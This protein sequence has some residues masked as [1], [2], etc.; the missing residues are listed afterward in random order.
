ME[1]IRK[2]DLETIV[3]RH[4]DFIKSR[5]EKGASATIALAT[6]EM[7]V[8]DNPNVLPALRTEYFVIGALASAMKAE[9]ERMEEES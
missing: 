8:Q 3:R 2:N 1:N 4:L 6:F 5:G 9:I 7:W